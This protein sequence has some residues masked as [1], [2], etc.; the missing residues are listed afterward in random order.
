MADE[1]RKLAEQAA[2]STKTI[3]QVVEELQINAQDAVSTM[4]KISEIA[5][6][7]TESVTR[8]GEKYKLIDNAMKGCQQ[9]VTELNLLGQEMVKMK[10]DILNTMESLSAIAEENSASTEEVTSL[11][12]QQAAA[13]RALS[14]ASENL[15][16]LAQDLQSTV[17]KFKL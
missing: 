8:S 14:E 7:Q 2:H 3:K 13:M 5:K 4:E 12:I 1:I 6:E 11:A 10:N 16:R 17:L 9:A 15:S